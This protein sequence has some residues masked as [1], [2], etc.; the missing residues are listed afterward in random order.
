MEDLLDPSVTEVEKI[1]FRSSESGVYSDSKRV[2]VTFLRD[3]LPDIIRCNYMRLP[4]RQYL[5]NPMRCTKCLNYG[6]TKKFC[7]SGV[8]MCGNCGQDYHLREDAEGNVQRCERPPHCLNCQQGHAVWDKACPR[9][10]QEKQVAEV[11]EIQ[12]V[13]YKTGKYMVQKKKEAGNT[14]ERRSFA[15]TVTMGAPT[16]STTQQSED[17]TELNNKVY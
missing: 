14:Q 5:P 15:D 7:D 2:I 1:Q 10:V 9:F 3:K 8:R 13:S 4:V 6:H 16:T 11:C 12:K 17:M